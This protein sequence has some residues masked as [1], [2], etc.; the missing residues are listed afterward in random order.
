MFGHELPLRWSV[1]KLVAARTILRG[2]LFGFPG[3]CQFSHVRRTVAKGS[4]TTVS[5]N[6][7]DCKCDTNGLQP[8][9]ELDCMPDS[10]CLVMRSSATPDARPKLKAIPGRNTKTDVVSV[11]FPAFRSDLL[12]NQPRI[13]NTERTT[14]IG[15]IALSVPSMASSIG[16]G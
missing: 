5:E 10:S 1:S 16:S 3:G 7:D 13:S 6:S 4:T 15:S 9:N 8:F 2:W 12:Y 14:S 11:Y